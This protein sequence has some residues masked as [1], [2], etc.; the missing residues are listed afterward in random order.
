MYHCCGT[1]GK[2]FFYEI[3]AVAMKPIQGKKQTALLYL[4]AVIGK[5]DDLRIGC[6]VFFDYIDLCK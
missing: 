2:S 3:V 1:L 5:V 4:A 6:A